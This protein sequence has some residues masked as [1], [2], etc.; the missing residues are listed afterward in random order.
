MSDA[1]LAIKQTDLF[2]VYLRHKSKLAILKV[3]EFYTTPTVTKVDL[4]KYFTTL[5]TYLHP[6]SSNNN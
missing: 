4:Q 3:N 2:L 1:N 6:S 5:A